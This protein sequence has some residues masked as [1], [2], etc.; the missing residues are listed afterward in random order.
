MKTCL[1][2]D[3]SNVVRKVARRI[4]ETLDLEITEADSGQAALEACQQGMPDAIVFDFHMPGM[5]TVEFLASLRAMA[6]G[7][8]PFVVY[9]TTDNDTP[10]IT[11]TLSAGADDYLIKPFDRDTLRAKLSAAGLV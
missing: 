10:D 11:R 7:K 4:L 5:G 3:D 9:C 1:I 6:N 2:V 8:K